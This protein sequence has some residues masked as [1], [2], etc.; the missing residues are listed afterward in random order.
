MS[1]D[2]LFLSEYISSIFSRNSLFY[3]VLWVHLVRS[4]SALLSVKAS[5]EV[6]SILRGSHYCF[7]VLGMQKIASEMQLAHRE[8]IC[9]FAAHL[10]KKGG[11]QKQSSFILFPNFPVTVAWTNLLPSQHY[12]R[13]YN[14]CL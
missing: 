14:Q 7:Q 5:L 8:S 11:R 2:V 3:D 10:K 12:C 1:I 9:L 6:I 4:R 13:C